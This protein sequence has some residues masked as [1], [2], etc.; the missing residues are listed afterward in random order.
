M[1]CCCVSYKYNF[2]ETSFMLKVEKKPNEILIKVDDSLSE[3]SLNDILAYIKVKTF[4]S[5]SELT[6]DEVERN[7]S[8]IAKA[9]NTKWLEK[10]RLKYAIRK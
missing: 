4:G 1:E 8:Q 2:N 5:K 3:E 9:I 6:D 10:N 7:A